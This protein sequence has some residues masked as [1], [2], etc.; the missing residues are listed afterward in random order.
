MLGGL[1]FYLSLK[2]SSLWPSPYLHTRA[3]PLLTNSLSTY[4]TTLVTSLSTSWLTSTWASLSNTIISMTTVKFPKFNEQM[5]GF[6]WADVWILMILFFGKVTQN[7]VG[8]MR[9]WLGKCSNL[10]GKCSI[11]LGKR[12][13]LLGKW[14]KF[15]GE[16]KQMDGEVK[17]NVLGRCPEGKMQYTLNKRSMMDLTKAGQCEF[18]NTNIVLLCENCWNPVE[19]VNSAEELVAKLQQLSQF[20]QTDQSRFLDA[21]IIK[22]WTLKFLVLNEKNIPKEIP[23]ALPRTCAALHWRWGESES[24]SRSQQNP[25]GIQ[26]RREVKN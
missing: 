15:V 9:K 25:P 12:S 3:K 16:M 19:G 22:R 8:E 10:L 26:H 14:S 18:F 11:L 6:L 24:A 5:S 7:C 13:N 4:S 21:K 20:K 17:Q 2:K 1:D 23:L